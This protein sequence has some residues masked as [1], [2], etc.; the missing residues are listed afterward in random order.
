MGKV[1]INTADYARQGFRLRA[2]N[3][4]KVV[5][6]LFSIGGV[7]RSGILSLNSNYREERKWLNSFPHPST[8]TLKGN[9]LYQVMSALLNIRTHLYNRKNLN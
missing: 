4:A 3:N 7:S 9:H 5:V 6:E 1:L 8:E 2:A